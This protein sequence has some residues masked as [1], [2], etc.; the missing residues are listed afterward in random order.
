MLRRKLKRFLPLGLMGLIWVV[1]IH[2]VW[3]HASTTKALQSTAVC[4]VEYDVVN[5]WG[6]GFQANVTVTNLESA[7]INGW[8]LAW[9]HAPGQDLVSGWNAAISQTGSE[10]TASNPAGHWNGTI[11]ENGGS[12]V[13]GMQV[14]HPGTVTIP[15]DFALNGMACLHNGPTP[16]VTPSPTL[17]PANAPDLEVIDA[18]YVGGSGGCNGGSASARISVRNNGM[19]DAGAFVVEI[20]GFVQETVPGL[21][22]GQE[23]SVVFNWGFGGPAT[24]IVDAT[25]LVAEYYETNNVYETFFPIPTQAPTCTPTATLEPATLNISGHV[26]NGSETGPG[27]AGVTIYRSIA[28]YPA[29]AVAT[30]DANGYYEVPPFDSQGHQE[31]VSLWADLTGYTFEPT[32]Y[33]WIYYGY[34]STVVRD[35]VA[36]AVATYTPTPTE[37]PTP[38]MINISGHVRAESSTGYGISGVTIYQSVMS[39]PS[40]PVATT[41][42]NGYYEV[43]PIPVAADEMTLGVWA[44]YKPYGYD[45]FVFEPPRYDWVYRTYNGP[46]PDFVRDFVAKTPTPPGFPGVDLVVVDAFYDGGTPPVCGAHPLD[47]GTRVVVAN[48]GT[49]DVGP[50]VVQLSSFNQQTVPGLAAGEQT[51]ILFSGIFLGPTTV[52]ADPDNLIA[53]SDETNNSL[54]TTIPIP[55]QPPACTPT[56]T[57]TSSAPA[58]CVVAYDVVNQWNNGFQV[59]IT[60]TNN[61]TAAIEGYTLAWD[62]GSGEQYGSGWNVSFNQSGT[63]M[64]AGNIVSHWNGT[65]GANG[66]SVSFGFNG[67]H[68]G[69]VTIPAQFTL[70]GQTCQ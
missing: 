66:G 7:D 20:N 58:N 9:T 21:A 54:S 34:G 28:S 2:V 70:N 24:I 16:T 31:T 52:V 45:I 41:D 25:D 69:V 60:I 39:T 29:V 32:Q 15:S 44:E 19:V 49:F 3:A 23:T 17:G 62:F 48:N 40:S 10:V 50:F 51:S 42:A 57:A 22:A 36:H 27:L 56:A 64:T 53:E 68:N 46:G 14:N 47:M 6:S 59:N 26:R 55:T 43:P 11:G 12:V 63:S 33:N 1:S 4:S 38:V 13:F 18:V 61:D 35:F 8:T 5:Q 37:T 65:I 67:S 30:T